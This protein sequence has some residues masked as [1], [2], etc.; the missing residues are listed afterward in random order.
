MIVITT[1]NE[2]VHF[3][4]NGFNRLKKYLLKAEG[5][6]SRYG[7]GSSISAAVAEKM[8]LNRVLPAL[9]ADN[10]AYVGTSS[11]FIFGE[12]LKRFFVDVLQGAD[13]FFAIF[14]LDPG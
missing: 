14:I 1:N 11:F 13:V 8:E 9:S 4:L 6:G 3:H 2:R 12:F 5:K 7:H 10:L